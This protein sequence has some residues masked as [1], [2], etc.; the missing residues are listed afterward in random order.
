MYI[1]IHCKAEAKRFCHVKVDH[2][3]RQDTQ[4][5]LQREW[6]ID[7]PKKIKVKDVYCFLVSRYE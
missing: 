3:L 7:H 4:N 1:Y 6:K 2:T 5:T